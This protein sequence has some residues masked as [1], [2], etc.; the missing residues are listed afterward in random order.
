[1]ALYVFV[2]ADTIS[3]F[4]E[5]SGYSA[6]HPRQVPL[7]PNSTDYFCPVCRQPV[8]RFEPIGWDFIGLLNDVG[9]IQP[10]FQGETFDPVNYF[11]PHCKSSDRDRLYALFL[12]QYFRKLDTAVKHR[13]ID[14]APAPRLSRFIRSFPMIDYRSAD[15]LAEGVDD[16]VDIMDM[17]IYETASVDFFLC[18][19]VLE[20]VPDDRKALHELYRVLK[21][22]KLGIIMVPIILL[23][24]TTYEDPSIVTPAERWKHFGQDDHLRIYAK[25][26]FVGK[27]QNAG[28]TVHQLDVT[29]FGT[30]LFVRHGIHRRSVLYIA[31]K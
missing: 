11:C 14:F 13:F 20:H 26:D 15:L 10:I 6:F 2:R 18:S 25:K 22:G 19:H 24:E 28:F 3:L 31:G 8:S 27:M 4:R 17:S 30:G 1:M 12:E 9:Y 7:M 21:P 16:R 23:L 5:R 29:V